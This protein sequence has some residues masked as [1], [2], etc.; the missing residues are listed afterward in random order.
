MSSGFQ[1]KMYNLEVIPPAGVWE[2]IAAELDE[3]ELHLEFPSRLQT[4]SVN[5]PAHIWQNISTALDE[6]F[7]IND[8]S[9]KLSG[10]EIAPP[11]SSWNKIKASLDEENAAAIIEHRRFSPFLKYAAAAAIIGFLAWGSLRLF[12]NKSPD[13]IEAKQD[14]KPPVNSEKSLQT[15]VVNLVKENSDSLIAASSSE[16]A[17]NDAALEASKRTYAKLDASLSRSKIKKAA[18]FFFASEDIDYIPAGT[19]RGLTIEPEVTPPIDI[20]KRY[21]LLMTPDG[22]IIRMSK[23]LRE[24]VCCVSGE[25]QDK[26]CVDQLKIWREKIASPSVSHSSGNFMNVLNIVNSVQEN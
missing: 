8:Y 16:E 2:K 26:D 1:N 13:I 3:A 4:I 11:A 12:N 24:L 21:I 19:I 9:G 5:P 15:E 22:Y 17:R 25:E 10:I 7:F 20:S 23:K 6:P 14:I 18:D